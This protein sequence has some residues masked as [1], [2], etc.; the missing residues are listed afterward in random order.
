MKTLKPSF[1]ALLACLAA[2]SATAV[3]AEPGYTC[4]TNRGC[5]EVQGPDYDIGRGAR[6]R[7]PSGWKFYTYPSAPDPIMAGL[8]EIRASRDG[9][10]IAI[11]PIPNIDNLKFTDLD[12]CE[13]MSK[14]AEQ[15]VSRSKE[16]AIMTVPIT[17]GD[18]VG[19]H[20]TFTAV[21]AGDKPFAVLSNRHH[22]TVTTFVIAAKG[23][24]FSVDAVSEHAPDDDYLAIV[25][26]IRQVE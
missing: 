22:A 20:A 12:L 4:D 17:H 21:H 14:G 5:K 6:L 9:M 1:F 2:A 16:Q 13:L 19:C 26:A 15:Y 7:L 3:A 8:R 10:V 24:V 11:T 25:D 23:V 18:T